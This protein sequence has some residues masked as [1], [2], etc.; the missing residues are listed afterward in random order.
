VAGGLLIGMVGL[1]GP[2]RNTFGRASTVESSLVST[3]NQEPGATDKSWSL[4][5]QA[6]LGMVN[7]VGIDRVVFTTDWPYAA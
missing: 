1:N 5:Y 4:G 3:A 6:Y 7:T 2:S